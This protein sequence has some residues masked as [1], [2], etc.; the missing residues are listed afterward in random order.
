MI[1]YNICF[2]RQGDRF[3]LLNREKPSWMG[4]WNGIGGKLEEGETPRESMEREI[5][6]ETGITDY[7]LHYKGLVTWLT[8]EAEIGGMY[9]YTAE[10][11]EDF[12]FAGPVKTEEGI[13]DW[14]KIDWILHP[15]NKGISSNIPVFFPYLL[16]EEGCY[17][18]FCDYRDGKLVKHQSVLLE[19][20][21]DSLEMTEFYLRNKGA[22]SFPNPS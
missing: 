20:A 19:I 9:L 2:I 1:T 3:L 10:V 12:V 16:H 8:N 7:K 15:Q 6:E 17:D 4:C 18:H 13:L 5:L 11:T 14:K 21:E 22:V